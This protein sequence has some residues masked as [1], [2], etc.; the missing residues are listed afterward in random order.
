MGKVIMSGRVP[1]LTTPGGV[2]ATDLAVGSSVYL[3]END[4]LTEYFVVQQGNPDSSKYTDSGADGIWLMRK[5]VSDYGLVTQSVARSVCYNGTY[6]ARFGSDVQAAMREVTLPRYS[7]SYG[8][9]VGSV[10]TGPV[11]PTSKVHLPAARELSNAAGTGIGT[12]VALLDFF[13][14]NTNADRIAYLDGTATGYHMYDSYVHQTGP[15]SGTEFHSR[16]SSSGAINNLTYDTED[17]GIRPMI[18]LD[19]NTIFDADTLTIKGVS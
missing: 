19:P 17:Y 12:N 2:P 3:M 9:V 13:A 4:V 6:L 18:I 7:Y 14:D 11:S 10:S 8:W 15:G 16:V 1:K 5:D